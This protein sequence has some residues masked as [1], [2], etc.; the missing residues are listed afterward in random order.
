MNRNGHLI[1][2]QLI[3]IV[4]LSVIIMYLLESARVITIF[5]SIGV[6]LFGCLAPDLDHEKVQ[7]KVF[8]FRWMRMFTKHRGHFHSL[9]ATVVYGL[10]VMIPATLFLTHWIYPVIFGMAGYVS[11]LIEDDINRFKLKSK[12]ERGFKLW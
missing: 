8:F 10:I 6:F 2:S 1:C 7:N 4:V 11:H 12:P 3:L 5:S 9:V